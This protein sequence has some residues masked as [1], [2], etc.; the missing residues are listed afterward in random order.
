MKPKLSKK[1]LPEK[2]CKKI[3]TKLSCNKLNKCIY[4][5]NKCSKKNK[6]TIWKVTWN[7]KLY[8]Y[9]KRIQIY[10]DKKEKNFDIFYQSKGRARMVNTPEIGDIVY[11][12]CD[13]KKILKCSV[14]TNFKE[15]ELSFKNNCDKGDSRPHSQTNL[16]IKLKILEAYNN[17]EP[18][19]GNQRTWT[20]DN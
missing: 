7:K 11:I 17:P 3:K 19:L 13:K 1:P 15:Q 20:K 5:N 2:Y 8:D 9:I 12:S 4:I 18:Y 14:E 16:Y 6:S 10:K